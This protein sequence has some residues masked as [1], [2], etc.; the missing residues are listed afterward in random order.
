MELREYQQRSLNL[1]Y[2]WWLDHPGYQQAPIC[3]LPTGC[4]SRD[5]RVVM[6]DGTTKAVQDIQVGDVLLGPDSTPRHVL[7]TVSGREPMYRITP[8][9]GSEPFVVNE[10]HVL[11]LMQTSEGKGFDCSTVSGR[12]DAITV[13]EY[14]E[15][16]KNW[17]HLR[18][19]HRANV[20]EFAERIA[21]PFD[22]WAL[23]ALLGD[24]SI[25]DGIKFTN[26]D[27]EILDAMASV[28]QAH[29]LS[30][31][32]GTYCRT[33]N[34][35]C[36]HV[37]F[38]D[39][40]ANR[41]TENR[42]A[43]ILREIGILGC[44]ADDK[45]VPDCYKLGSVAV[46]CAVLSG[47]LDTD[48]HLTRNCCY[49]FISKSRRLSEDVVF[50]ARSLG[51]TACVN[52]CEKRCQT[53][54][55][56]TYWRV[57]LSGDMSMLSLRCSRKRAPPRKQKKNNL[58][59]GFS[60]EPVGIGEFFGFTL[61]GDHLYMTDDFV[62]HHNSG[63]SVVIAELCRLLF[64]T[65]PEHHPRTVVLVP[66]KELAEQNAAKLVAMMPSHIKV[67]YYSASL[68]RKQPNADVIVATIGSIYK[69]AHTLGNIKCVVIDECHGVNPD[70]NEIGRYRQF[71]TDLAKLCQFR[72]VGYTAT[73]F[74]GNGVWLTDGDDPLFTGVAVTITMQELLNENYL[75]PL[76]RPID[77]VKTQID[78]TGIKT[79][80]G[81]Y[82]LHD[83]ELRVQ[84]YIPALAAEAVTL[85]ADR[86]KWI[87]F[88][89]TVVNAHQLSAELRRHGV[90]SAVVTGDTPKADREELIAQ[91]RQG[92]IRCLIT[93]LAL[94]TGF[95]VP[96]V[97]CILW[98]RPTQSPVLYVQGCGR[99]MRIADGKTDCLWLD[100]S[101]TTER[102]GPVDMIRGRKR[103]KRTVEDT[104]APT[105]VCD[106]CGERAPAAAPV[107]PTCG[108]EFPQRE[109]EVRQ[110]SNAAIMASQI[111]PKINTYPVDRVDY[112]V[113]RKPGSPDSLR[114]D[115]YSGFRK[116]CSEWVCLEHGGFAGAKA[117]NWMQRRIHDMTGT[118][119]STAQGLHEFA[120]LV[121][122][123][124]PER[125]TINETGK[126]PEIIKHHWESHE[127]A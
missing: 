73:P 47:L 108:Y 5:T 60:V 18:K 31:G 81:D 101:D 79:T 84:D 12:L 15:K 58:V 44:R 13:R 10:N 118:P 27:V 74:R 111:A 4:H 25:I 109:Q 28:M 124:E 14:L 80:S 62:V 38:V 57:C 106:Q 69:A 126:F 9:R 105:K 45:F 94:A 85:A 11:S 23:G 107:C 97:D 122:L 36:W 66:S 7:H 56:G 88:C 50:I 17:K 112:A 21:P 22:A 64:D 82:N 96:D 35:K 113:H 33:V 115:Y 65:W 16:S 46:R 77:A 120:T 43:G 100:F 91:F 116:V 63:K 61:D 49:D 119:P 127:S 98:C 54:G 30:V 92:H 6:L 72:V 89:A 102:L 103:S 70:G 39:K 114:V 37:S 40:I 55:G 1:L 26:P 71:L 2:Q 121:G 104:Q 52:K 48:G 41:S 32:K 110:A 51:L 87:S 68:G 83:L 19:L 34:I 29:G 125:I 59:S 90:V 8:L 86:R 78:T 20:V 93:V 99:G 76:V 53:G 24:G 75:S 95:D 117:A 42:V 3:T 67:G 123:L